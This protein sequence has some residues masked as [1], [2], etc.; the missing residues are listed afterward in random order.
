[1]N[2]VS[3][4]ASP[5]EVAKPVVDAKEAEFSAAVNNVVESVTAIND[6]I[7]RVDATKELA[8]AAATS[9]FDQE[10]NNE[11]IIELATPVDPANP[12]EYNQAAYEQLNDSYTSY[13]ED[14]AS[15][16]KELF[17]NNVSYVVDDAIKLQEKKLSPNGVTGPEQRKLNTFMGASSEVCLAKPPMAPKPLFQNMVKPLKV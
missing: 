15:L 2:E 9:V 5:A 17:Q 1:M 7:S 12:T 3:T 8:K 4:Q 11:A 16:N 10:I 14:I 13:P 6:P